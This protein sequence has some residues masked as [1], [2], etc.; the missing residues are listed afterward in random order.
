MLIFF[1]F[2]KFSVLITWRRGSAAVSSLF[3]GLLSQVMMKTESHSQLV[4]LSCV[5]LQPLCPGPASSVLNIQQLS[6]LIHLRLTSSNL[7]SNITYWLNIWDL[8]PI[9]NT[10]L[11]LLER[12]VK[13]HNKKILNNNHS[14][15]T[16]LIQNF[17][18]LK[19]LWIFIY[20]V[21]TRELSKLWRQ[22]P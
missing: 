17:Q 2:K 21:P 9:F 6:S 3:S 4:A 8:F 12:K 20:W 1:S 7:Q 19:K 10:K 22:M 16:K 13:S 14:P 11:N 18:V 15:E 5:W